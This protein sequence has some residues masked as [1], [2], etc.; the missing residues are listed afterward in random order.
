MPSLKARIQ[1][2][3]SLATLEEAG[4]PRIRALQTSL[5]FGFAA[6]AKRIAHALQVEGASLHEAMALY[7][8]IF[9]AFERNM[10]AVGEATGRIDTVCRSLA[11]WYEFVGAIRSK[12]IGG[13]LY[14]LL[15]Y[16]LAA[17]MIPFISTITSETPAETAM[18]HGIVM[19]AA[20]WALLLAWKL[21]GQIVLAI[22]GVSA[23]LLEIPLLGGLLYR[24]DCARFFQAYAMGL[25]AGLGLFETVRLG[26][27]ACRNPTMRKRFH[28]MGD[29]MRSEGMGFTAAFLARPSARDRASMIPAIMQTGE[30][31]G[32]SAEMAE[33]IARISRQEAETTIDRT[34]RVAPTLLYLCLAAYIGYRIIQFYDRILRP[35]RELL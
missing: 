4:V 33:R 30:E 2:Y 31:T 13:L 35:V 5:P 26:A 34:A 8:G 14:P 3:V 27:D 29:A 22:P 10:I 1:F 9:S 16:H 12:V 11:Q 15:V 24:L 28:R 20:P 6:P 21:F 7:P 18:R 25:N 32:R 17:I 23:V 19:L